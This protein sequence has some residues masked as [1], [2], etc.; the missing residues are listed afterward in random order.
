MPELSLIQAAKATGR[1]KSTIHRAIKSGR[2]SAAR[3]DDGSYAIQPAEL[4]RAFPTEP[5]EPPEMG[6][7]GT[8]D[9][10]KN[11]DDGA[12]VLAVKV[13]MLSE[14]LERERD[15]VEDLRRRLDRAEERLLAL[16]PPRVEEG[17]RKG[18][19][20]RLWGLV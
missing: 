15:T 20:A 4:F 17:R 19:W 7:S 10:P 9:E 3:Q 13:A 12:A 16:A 1:S 8:G 5:Q 18:L 14:Q 2:L 6:Q 11:T